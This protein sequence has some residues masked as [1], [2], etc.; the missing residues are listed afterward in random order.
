MVARWALRAES[1]NLLPFCWRIHTGFFMIFRQHICYKADKNQNVLKWLTSQAALRTT[2]HIF[3]VGAWVQFRS[4]RNFHI[5]IRAFTVKFPQ[6][7]TCCH[8]YATRC[9]SE[10]SFGGAS[11]QRSMSAQVSW[12]R[13]ARERERRLK[14]EKLNSI[15][16]WLVFRPGVCL[17]G[18]IPAG[19]ERGGALWEDESVSS[20]KVKSWTRTVM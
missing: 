6:M 19:G 1:F 16:V 18:D 2:V 12:F 9:S 20:A 4:C 13:R 3:S 7:W 14:Q 17:Q 5:Y 8:I 15:Q 11:R 10:R